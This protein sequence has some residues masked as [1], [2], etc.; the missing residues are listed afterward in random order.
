M[1]H[2]RAVVPLCFASGME[3]LVQVAGR[4]LQ[5]TEGAGH[6]TQSCLHV[7]KRLLLLSS[8]STQSFKSHFSIA[9]GDGREAG[10]AL[11]VPAGCWTDR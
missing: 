3:L 9:R 1:Y 11:I 2:H 6:T 10:W 7:P 8:A 5:G 4:V